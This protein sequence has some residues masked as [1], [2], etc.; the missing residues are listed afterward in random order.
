MWIAILV[1]L[2]IYFILWI[3]YVGPE[4]MGEKVILGR[5]VAF[6]D[7][8]FHLVPFF[9]GCYLKKF[10][11]TLFR[12]N[13]RAR[14]AI[15]DDGIYQGKEYGKVTIKVDSVVYLRLPNTHEGLKRI[16]EQ[17]IPTT[18]ESLLE[19][20]QEEIVG[21]QRAV[22]G[23]ATWPYVVE[24]RKA[25]ADAVEGILKD[26]SSSLKQAGFGDDDIVYTIEEINLPSHLE[27]ALSE[28]EAG[29]SEARQ[30]AMET[31]G[32]VLEMMAHSYGKSLEEIQQM[33]EKSPKF[34]KEFRDKAFD[35]LIRRMGAE[36]GAYLD[37]RVEGAQ[38]AERLL[39]DLLA[40]WKRM[41]RG[42]GNRKKEKQKVTIGGQEYE[43]ETEKE[44]G[45]G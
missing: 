20:F 22:I 28:A 8:G 31:I 2:A 17:K 9:F 40:A 33:I 25:I 34:K 7:S 13:I 41:P 4:E 26:P 23:K 24:E 42:Q 39:L 12:L 5:P 10:P 30:R 15:T 45:G 21:A 27:S 38:G 43:V 35:L 6:V 29:K 37:I 11:K 14:T 19:F 16:F 3:K 18:A 1:I 36:W 44:K 32:A